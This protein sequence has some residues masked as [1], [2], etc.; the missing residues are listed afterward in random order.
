VAFRLPQ[1]RAVAVSCFGYL[2][3]EDWDLMPP[4]L[5]QRAIGQ[6]YA[7]AAS[8]SDGSVQ[9]VGCR[10][11]GVLGSFVMFKPWA[12]D[13]RF[14]GLTR[15]VA[16]APAAFAA[17]PPAA[18]GVAR[19]NPLAAGSP[20]AGPVAAAGRGF[21][22]HTVRCLAGAARDAK[23]ATRSQAFWAIGNFAAG[24]SLLAEDVE[25]LEVKVSGSYSCRAQ[26][27]PQAHNVLIFG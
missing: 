17:A 26:G 11:V 4:T 15:R 20:V 8:D 22:E 1:V 19:G 2:L 25:A 14:P 10:V 24:M 6:V 5:R 27:E 18:W 16:S 12:R 13:L 23:V 9:A 7:T 3:P 21:V